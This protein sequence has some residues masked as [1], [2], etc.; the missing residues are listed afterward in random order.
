LEEE[1]EE[2]E[3]RVERGCW[4]SVGRVGVSMPF[5]KLAVS[6]AALAAFVAA[7]VVALVVSVTA[8]FTTLMKFF[9][10]ALMLRL[11]YCQA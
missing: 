5:I 4:L 3:E 7:F 6:L 2:E 9:I 8:L 1:E 10:T 11:F